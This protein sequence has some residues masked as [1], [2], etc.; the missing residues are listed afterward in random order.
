M[1]P[2][3]TLH[4]STYYHSFTFLPLSTG[5]C[6]TSLLL[7]LVILPSS[8]SSQFQKQNEPIWERKNFSLNSVVF[9]P[10]D[11]YIPTPHTPT[12]SFRVHV[13]E[14]SLVSQAV[15]RMFR[16]PLTVNLARKSI[17]PFYHTEPVC[18][19]RLVLYFGIKVEMPMRLLIIQKIKCCCQRCYSECPTFDR[20]V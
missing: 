3:P 14:V 15:S 9:S 6:S 7:F 8:L 20:A 5:L 17:S 1:W 11:I 10:S 13:L 12:P 19:G 2:H 4:R 18:R 16:S